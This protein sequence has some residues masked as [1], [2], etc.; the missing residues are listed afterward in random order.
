VGDTQL[1]VH[2]A[3]LVE[4]ELVVAHRAE[5][6]NGYCYELAWDGTGRDGERFVLGLAAPAG[7]DADRSGPG[8]PRSGPGRS[9]VGRLSALVGT[10]PHLKDNRPITVCRP[11][12]PMNAPNAV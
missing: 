1:K 3:R 9:P 4:L 8:Q 11:S 10:A 6:G 12:V 5:R 7:N 2:L